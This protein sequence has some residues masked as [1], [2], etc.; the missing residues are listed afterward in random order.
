[1]PNDIDGSK[2]PGQQTKD[3]STERA[4]VYG[5]RFFKVCNGDM[6]YMILHPAQY[7]TWDSQS[8]WLYLEF[9]TVQFFC[10]KIT[11]STV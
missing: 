10:N 7:Y 3:F 2:S 1:M 9:G 5:F 4:H 11:N 8:L 6:H